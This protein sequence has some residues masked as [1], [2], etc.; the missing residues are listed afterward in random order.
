MG[1]WGNWTMGQLENGKM[2]ELDNWRMEGVKK[3]N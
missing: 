2:R 3:N 1:E